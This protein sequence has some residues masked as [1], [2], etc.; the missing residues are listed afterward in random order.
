[1]VNMTIKIA[2]FADTHLGYRQYGLNQRENDYY[3]VFNR[4]IDDMIEKD[5]DYV[6]H[7][8][9]LFDQAKPPIKALLTAQK[10]FERLKEADIPVYTIAGNHDKVQKKNSV[11]PQKIFENDNFHIL[12]KGKKVVLDDKI[13][14]GGLPYQP[15][16]YEKTMQSVLEDMVQEAKDY[17][18]SIIM[19]HGSISKYFDINPEFELNTVP[20]GFSYYAM[21]HW[22]RRI[23]DEFK[24]GK[25]SYPSSTEVH[26][27]DEIKDFEEKSKGYN[28]ITI[29][30]EG[31]HEPEYINIPLNRSFIQRIIDY[32]KI[33]EELES[34]LSEVYKSIYD[35]KLDVIDKRP[36][37]YL[38]V[39]N[40]D[41]D[42]EE[43]R[44]KIYDKLADDTLTIN[45]T[46]QP[47]ETTEDALEISN[48]DDLSPESAIK[49][50]VDIEFEN[51]IVTSLAL[52][53]YIDLSHENIES[54]IKTAESYYDKIYGKGD[55]ENDNT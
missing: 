7:S 26:S 21:G 6:L 35:N 27:K 36:I 1:M 25:L 44:T 39:T 11:I 40:G 24:N 51:D 55:S 10:G 18:Y 50:K 17:E 38:T 9:D 16:R 12:T 20:E 19:L 32:P 8:G 37:L 15:K 23:I 2:H 43:V 52:D 54:G 53:L 47:I 30:E 3:D 4:I 46:Y 34:I 29:D 13:Y 49:E 48:I 33:D 42:R 31:L 45:I 41:F 5:V 14:L 28:L 22:H